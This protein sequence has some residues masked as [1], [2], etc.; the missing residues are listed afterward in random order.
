VVSF[1]PQLLYLR[2][3][4]PRYPLGRR[5][6]GRWRGETNFL[7]CFS[8]EWN[9]GLPTPSLVTILITTTVHTVHQT[10]PGAVTL[11]SIIESGTERTTELTDTVPHYEGLTATQGLRLGRLRQ[12]QLDMR[13][14]YL[15]CRVCVC[16]CVC[17]CVCGL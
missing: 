16:M 15:L 6:D 1:A 5:V 9:P 11:N 10:H 14:C 12:Q 8:R 7:R 17:V 3:K 4:S 2:E 13:F